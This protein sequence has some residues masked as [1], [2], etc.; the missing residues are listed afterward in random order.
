M[1]SPVLFL[2]F[3]RPDTTERVF[4]EIRKARP[5]RLYVAADGPRASRPGEKEICEKT[6]AIVGNVDWPCEVKTLFRDVNLGCGHAVSQASLIATN[7]S[8]ATATMSVSSLSPVTTLFTK[9]LSQNT[10]TICHRSSISG[11]GRLGEGSGGH[12]SSMP[13]NYPGRYSW[14]KWLRVCLKSHM[15]TGLAYST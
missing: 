7:C 2:I 15:P 12:M 8:D 1:K 11:V 5:P 3:N 14:K 9:A 6:R 4:E 13:P 10:P